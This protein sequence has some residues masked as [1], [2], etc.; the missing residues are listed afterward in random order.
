MILD[1][2]WPS[3]DYR[4]LIDMWLQ[5]DDETNYT[6]HETIQLLEKKFKSNSDGPPRSYD[7]TPCDLFLWGFVKSKVYA[8]NLRNIP[9]LERIIQKFID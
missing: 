6:K 8:G 9:E 1:F 3:L 4:G 2:P 7:L 5:Q